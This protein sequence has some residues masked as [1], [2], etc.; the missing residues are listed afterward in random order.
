[1]EFWL[2]NCCE[3]KKGWFGVDFEEKN[4]RIYKKRENLKGNR[5]KPD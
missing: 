4:N 1:M 5:Q 3:F 2:K